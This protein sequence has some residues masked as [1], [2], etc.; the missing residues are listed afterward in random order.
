M[1]KLCTPGGHLRQAAVGDQLARPYV[2]PPEGGAVP[3]HGGEATVAQPRA[4]PEAEARHL[5]A[6]A[7]PAE[8]PED[9][10]DGQVGVEAVPGEADRPPEARVPAEKVQ[11]P[12]GLAAADEAAGVEV[13]EDGGQQV[14]GEVLEAERAFPPGRRRPGLVSGGGVAGVDPD[15]AVPVR[16]RLGRRDRGRP[17]PDDAPRAGEPQGREVHRGGR[18]VLGGRGHADHRVVSLVLGH[19]GELGERGRQLEGRRG[20]AVGH[21]LGGKAGGR[22]AAVPVER[23]LPRVRGGE[24]VGQLQGG[25]SRVGRSAQRAHLVRLLPMVLVMV[26]VGV[27]VVGL[28]QPPRVGG[29]GFEGVVVVRVLPRVLRAAA[30]AAQVARLLGEEGGLA[31][32]ARRPVRVPGH[33][34]HVLLQLLLPIVRLVL[35]KMGPKGRRHCR[36]I[37]RQLGRRLAAVV[38]RGGGRRRVGGMRPSRPAAQVRGGGVV[39][40]EGRVA[41]VQR[42]RVGR[43]AA[44]AVAAVGGVGEAGR[45]PRLVVVVAVRGR[46][47]V[48]VGRRRRRSEV[49]PAVSPPRDGGG[50]VGGCAVRLSAVQLHLE[51]NFHFYFFLLLF[52]NW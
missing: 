33:L 28:L 51:E 48:A 9:A 15:E 14:V 37:A 27:G 13:G 19:G 32:V 39:R 17:R 4:P 10:G 12:A 20:G 8:E 30:A 16:R 11:P 42:R 40:Q 22:R 1:L 50:H 5:A 25:L 7:A 52:P 31:A 23:G 2:E 34:A 46:L 35:Q 43:A 21:V 38:R 18:R 3:G 6:L 24:V 29:R 44:D 41:A 45:R 47:G 36:G 26:L 49:R